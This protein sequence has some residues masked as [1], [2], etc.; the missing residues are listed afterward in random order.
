M[1]PNP[2]APSP[3]KGSAALPRTPSVTASWPISSSSKTKASTSSRQVLD[4]H[5]R[6]FNPADDVEHDAVDEMAAAHWRIRRLWSIQTNLMNHC[7]ES[8]SLQ[9][10]NS[11]VYMD[12]IAAAFS[13]LA[14]GKQLD[15]LE[16]Y[17]TRLH[18]MYERSFLRLKM[19]QTMDPA[20]EPD[21]P[22]ASD[23]PE[24]PQPNPQPKPEPAP[25]IPP[26]PNEPTAPSAPGDFPNPIS[27]NIKPLNIPHYSLPNEPKP[28][29]V[30]SENTQSRQ[31]LVLEYCSVKQQFTVVP[32]NPPK[33]K[34][35]DT[36]TR[37]LRQ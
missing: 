2:V 24:S 28:P 26:I 30:P 5:I 10:S 7:M 9:E 36:P 17:E 33:Q 25:E 27:A 18:R 31:G 8:Q 19:L 12:P 23:P 13:E 11:S 16:R 21:S 32:A 20:P 15:R 22:Q 6:K 1:A 14:A 37:G 29:A 3:K 4:Q 35:P 34:L